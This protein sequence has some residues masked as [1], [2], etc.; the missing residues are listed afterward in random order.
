MPPKPSFLDMHH[1]EAPP[2]IAA[3]PGEEQSSLPPVFRGSE[4]ELQLEEVESCGSSV[5]RWPGADEASEPAAEL[6]P[7]TQAGPLLRAP[8]TGSE[9]ESQEDDALQE[10]TSQNGLDELL[11]DLDVDNTIS[12]AEKKELGSQ[13]AITPTKVCEAGE[14]QETLF[15]KPPSKVEEVKD[16]KELPP[17][18]LMSL[19]PMPGVKT[20]VEAK[21]KEPDFVAESKPTEVSSLARKDLAA[22]DIRAI[23]KAEVASELASVFDRIDSLKKSCD[24]LAEELSRMK[25]SAAE[26]LDKLR[27]RICEA[28]AAAKHSTEDVEELQRSVKKELFDV[29]QVFNSELKDLSVL[30]EDRDAKFEALA[31]KYCQA[32][33]D[34]W[35]SK[36]TTFPGL[37]LASSLAR[38]AGNSG[39]SFCNKDLLRLDNVVFGFGVNLIS[40]R[41]FRRNLDPTKAAAQSLMLSLYPIHFFYQLL[42]YTD[43]G[44]LFWVLLVQDLVT[45]E[46][47]QALP[48][49]RRISMAAAAGAVAVLFRQTNA[50]WL[51]FSFGTAALQDLQLSK[52]VELR[53]EDL[54]LLKLV[55][56]VKALLLE[57]RRLLG[58]LGIMLVPVVLFVLFVV[59]NGSIVVGDHSNH[60]VAP[61]WAQLC[62]LSAVVAATFSV[63][64]SALSPRWLTTFIEG[65]CKSLSRFLLSA[66]AL[67]LMVGVVHKYSLAHPFLLADN[68]HYTFYLWNRFLKRPW[69][70]DTLAPAYLY[71]AW[72]ISKRLSQAQSGLWVLIWWVA[73]CLTLVPAPLLEPRY[74][75]T[76]VIMAH[77]HFYD[78]SWC[79][80][81]LLTTG[82]LVVNI[83]TL[84]V[85]AYKPFAW[86]S[87]EIA[88][89]MW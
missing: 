85:F 52:W 78:R 9:K 29:Q 17:A 47:G 59:Y 15:A 55:T 39:M 65:C 31:Q 46:R 35:D 80:I 32:K 1:F 68:R 36:I 49:A 79:S 13:A 8:L 11:P 83:L 10:T 72:Y 86:P 18:I 74:W 54:S 89:F 27:A 50:V 22:D 64:D 2:R 21:L 4:E 88:R 82:Y 43:V 44:S 30:L 41:L 76:A 69:L 34:E 66:L 3:Q 16:G 33:F 45:P 12:F 40:Y 38:G 63:D 75:T 62:Y 7:V 84:T 23:V 24:A 20:P 70:R 25:G 37:Y 71:A 61:H 67:A 60:E 57:S 5:A 87:G 77:L 28:P 19:A 58:R 48:T 73:A 81:V 53:G 51:M 42:Y 14:N 56:F 6:T 26:E